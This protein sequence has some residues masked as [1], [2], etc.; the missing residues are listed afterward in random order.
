VSTIALEPLLIL[1]GLTLG[2]SHVDRTT[3]N[4][5]VMRCDAAKPRP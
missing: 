1:T 5:T 3:A 2:H 4:G